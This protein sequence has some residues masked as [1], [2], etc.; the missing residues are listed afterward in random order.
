MKRAHKEIEDLE[1]QRKRACILSICTRLTEHAKDVLNTGTS[2]IEALNANPKNDLK[3]YKYRLECL[4]KM[5]ASVCYDFKKNLEIKEEDYQKLFP[6]MEI[7]LEDNSDKVQNLIE[8]AKQLIH[9]RTYCDRM[10]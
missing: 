9:M 4:N 7:K 3:A 2:V 6:N 5:Y 8:M 10:L 1:K